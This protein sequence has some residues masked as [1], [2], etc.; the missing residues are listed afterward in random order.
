MLVR[1][2]LGIRSLTDGERINKEAAKLPKLPSPYSQHREYKIV[3]YRGLIP[4]W[5]AEQGASFET[6]GVTIGACR[7]INSPIHFLGRLLTTCHL[8]VARMVIWKG[9]PS[10]IYR[11]WLLLPPENEVSSYH[12]H[13]YD[14]VDRAETNHIPVSYLIAAPK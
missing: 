11:H 7:L 5:P 14:L 10:P 13:E 12:S 8:I 2:S 9:W 4:A 1:V 6:D 3:H